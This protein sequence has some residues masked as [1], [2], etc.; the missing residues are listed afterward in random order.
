MCLFCAS[1]CSHSETIW[2]SGAAVPSS[3]NSRTADVIRIQAFLRYTIYISACVSVYYIIG[4]VSTNS[5]VQSK[6]I[7][8]NSCE[9]R[10]N[11]NL[12]GTM[13]NGSAFYSIT[14]IGTTH[15]HFLAMALDGLET[16]HTTLSQ[17]KLSCNICD[18]R[19]SNKIISSASA[20][21]FAHKHILYLYGFHFCAFDS[22]FCLC[23]NNILG[24]VLFVCMCLRRKTYAQRQ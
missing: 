5:T 24:R 15:S 16:A 14:R 18:A 17:L 22:C 6:F 4:A 9:I 21:A 19:K 12:F 1:E 7:I 20:M 11:C 10:S 2:V 13:P 23:A 3:S 8:V